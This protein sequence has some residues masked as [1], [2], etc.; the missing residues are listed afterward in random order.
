[1]KKL[2]AVQ[3]SN[4]KFDHPL[5]GHV[6]FYQIND[7]EVIMHHKADGTFTVFTHALDVRDRAGEAPLE[8]RYTM[9]EI[10]DAIAD[11]SPSGLINF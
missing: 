7:E 6:T 9:D 1:V 10:L 3:L 8:S 4:A 11:C 5:M 2:E